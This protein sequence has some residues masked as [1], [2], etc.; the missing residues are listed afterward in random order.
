MRSIW[1][2][3]ISFGLVNIPVGMYPATRDNQVSFN[4]LHEKDG[5]RIHNQRV[6]KKCGETVEYEELIKGYEYEK[7]HYVTLSDEELRK[8]QPDANETITILD[9]VDLEDIDPIYFDRPYYL[10]P[11]KKSDKVY[12][13]LREALKQS[14]KVGVAK[15][16]LRT[17]EYLAAVRASGNALVLDTMH[18]RDEIR[19]KEEMPSSDVEVGKRELDMAVQLIDAMAAE[20]DPEKY[21][22]SYSEALMQVVEKKLE[23]KKI[24]APT[25]K[26]E[27]TNVL[28]LMSRLKASLEG[29]GGE[30]EET[31]T[32][33]RGTR[34]SAP[35]RRAARPK[36]RAAGGRK[37]TT[38][39]SG[40][41]TRLR[42][43]A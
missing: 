3:M 22:D 14:K 29:T 17:K 19:D 18:F 41:K 20:F 6:C 13:L 23:G 5:G 38:R 33:A 26:K 42:L 43:V 11:S 4:L 27:P 2:G 9:F 35:A 24:T 30:G 32:K 39:K 36:T 21:H 1:N 7:G 8:V 31:K 16:V 15:F 12:V 10:I 28:D 25:H 37:T 40:D 34:K